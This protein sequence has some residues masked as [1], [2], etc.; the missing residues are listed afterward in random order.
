[1]L[2][3]EILQNKNKRSIL[4]DS[5]SVSWAMSLIM[6]LIFMIGLADVYIAGRFG[7][8]VQAAYGLSFQ[9]YF[10]FLIIAMALSVGTVS[11]LSRLF[12]SARL[13]QLR[14]AVSSSLATVIGTGFIF[15]II[16]FFLSTKI[17]DIINAPSEI[18]EFAGPLISIYFVGLVFH[19]IMMNTNAILRACK[20]TRRSLLT[21]LVVCSLNIGLNFYLSLHTPLKFKGIAVSTVISLF[22]GSIL[23]ISH[24]IFLV[25]GFTRFSWVMMKKIAN[26]SW[27]AGLLQILWQAGSMVIFLILSKL[28]VYN[29]ETMAAFTNGLKIESAIFLPAFAFNMSNGVIV[30]NL[31]GKKRKEDAF[32]GGILTALIG[33]IIVSIMSAIVILNSRSIASFL[34]NDPVVIDRCTQYI[35]I[36]LLFEPIMAWGVILGGGLNGAGDTRSVMTIVSLSVWVLRIPLSCIFGVYLGYGAIAI[37]W[38]MNLSIIA[39]SFFITTRYFSKRWL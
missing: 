26:I 38:C 27:P 12:G 31:L 7:K 2:L 4:S 21:M 18:K 19:Y 24:V 34:S 13:G 3:K 9:I 1:M 25:K 10:I 6:F 14:V 32:H 28:P 5:W 33:V 30:G 17:L 35:L 29:I 23:N 16:G 22:V 39:Q 15:G 37:W 11:V 8:E 36:T 20:L